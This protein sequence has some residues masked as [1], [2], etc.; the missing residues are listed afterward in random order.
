MKMMASI[1][2]LEIPPEGLQ[3]ECEIL[4]SELALSP[5]DG[6]IIGGLKCSGLL[7]WETDRSLSFHGTLTGNMTRECV[8]CLGNF[9]DP[10]ALPCETRFRESPSTKSD[11]VPRKSRKAI[12]RVN[13]DDEDES[14]DTYSIEGNQIDLLLPVREQLILATPLQALCRQDCLGLCQVCGGNLN[15]H[16]C[17]CFSPVTV[18]S[19][20]K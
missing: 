18:S 14:E 10:I 13:I 11:L 20:T 16:I 9:N 8:R 17:A 19:L 15:E 4:S 6:T 12:H 5:N 1:N 2:I 3:V 7:S